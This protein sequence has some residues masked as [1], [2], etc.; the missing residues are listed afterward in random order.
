MT[1]AVVKEGGEYK[2]QEVK[3]DAITSQGNDRILEPLLAQ[4]AKINS[5][6][7]RK[8]MASAYFAE[9]NRIGLLDI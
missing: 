3:V 9:S 7:L 2:I 4:A 1:L 6:Y 5:L 8:D